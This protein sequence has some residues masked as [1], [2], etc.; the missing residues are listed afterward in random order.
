MASAISEKTQCTTL[1][2]LFRDASVEK[3]ACALQGAEAELVQRT[4]SAAGQSISKQ[5]PYASFL[6]KQSSTDVHSILHATKEEQAR[7]KLELGLEDLY[8][9]WFCDLVGLEQLRA[10]PVVPAKEVN[11]DADETYPQYWVKPQHLKTSAVRGIW[12]IEYPRPFV[13]VKI[14]LISPATK[15]V[16]ATVVEVIFKRYSVNRDGAK[17]KM[18]E[19][20]YVTALGNQTDEGEKYGS[21]LYSSG[22]MSSEQIQALRDLL[23]G[24]E[25]PAPTD[26][27]FLIRMVQNS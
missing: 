21:V 5:C 14:E 11:L 26:K 10:L 24:K 2:N 25:I 3:L 9:K 13:A 22:G 15:K 4:Q 8:G 23:A 7:R 20:N 27:R 17:G 1:A 19:D 6:R 16:R 18:M 12:G